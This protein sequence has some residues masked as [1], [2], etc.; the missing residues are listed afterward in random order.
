MFL[1]W[2]DLLT[3]GCEYACRQLSSLWCSELVAVMSTSSGFFDLRGNGGATISF[4]ERFA[5]SELF[6][7]VFKEG[8]A[9]VECTAAYLDGDGRK[10]AK[11]LK[12]PVSVIYAS[13]SMRLTTRLLE[14]ASWLLVRRGLKEG[15][16]T[17]AEAAK[18]RERIKLRPFG[19]PTHVQHF[20][21]L[22]VGLRVLIE[23][24]FAL[25]DRIIQLDRAIERP[26][27]LPVANPVA[28]QMAQLHRAFGPVGRR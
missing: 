8:M 22:P 11:G 23:E 5:S 4:G 27:D 6:D 16:L 25:N 10:D 2:D 18:K 17:P 28:N 14:L 3:V 15:E 20:A 12:P 21:E 24:S 13:E 26:A 19:R 7:G 1:F 9:L